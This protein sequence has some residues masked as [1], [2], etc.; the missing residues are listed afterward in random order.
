[1]CEAL[2]GRRSIEYLDKTGG[3]FLEHLRSLTQ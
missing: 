3:I 2:E 1:M